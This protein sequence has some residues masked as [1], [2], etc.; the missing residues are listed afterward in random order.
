MMHA[1]DLQLVS[2]LVHARAGIVLGNAATGRA[3]AASGDR[4]LDHQR[5]LVFPRRSTV[6]SAH[7]PRPAEARRSPGRRAA[8]ADLERCRFE[9]PGSLLDRDVPG[10]AGA[11][12]SGW[13]F[14][15]LGTDIAESAIERAQQGR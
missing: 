14:S 15:I 13:R 5:D 1:A 8:A 9:L 7:R 12:V 10:R 6:R 11:T 3:T 2:T 4:G